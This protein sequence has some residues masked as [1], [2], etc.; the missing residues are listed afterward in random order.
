MN[1]NNANDLNLWEVRHDLIS[2]AAILTAVMGGLSAWWRLFGNALPDLT[3]LFLGGL[4][5]LGLAVR[6]LNTSKPGAARHL[7]VWGLTAS[8]L[9]AMMLF[10]FTW[11]PFLALLLP[12]ISILLVKYS[13]WVIMA[14][15]MVTALLLERAGLRAYSFPELPFALLTAAIAA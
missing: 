12:F 3:L 5:G 7:L 4:L 2:R 6:Q 11:I 10:P 15:V 9:G 14:L 13:E 1:S 8:L